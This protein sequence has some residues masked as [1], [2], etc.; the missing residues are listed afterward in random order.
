MQG[1]QDD[2]ENG[3]ECFDNDFK[4]LELNKNIDWSWK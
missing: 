3:F 4:L 2:E 1:V